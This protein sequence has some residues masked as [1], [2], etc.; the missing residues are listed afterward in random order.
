MCYA[1]RTLSSAER[2]QTVYELECAAAVFGVTK[3]KQYLEVAPF[4]LQTDNAALSWLFEHPKQIGKLGRWILLLSRFKFDIKHIKGRCNNVADC[5]SRMYEG[6]EEVNCSALRE[7]PVTN[8]SLIRHQVNDK[9]CN[10][11]II[12]INGGT[13]V[14][15]YKIKNELLCRQIGKLFS[16]FAAQMANS[17]TCSLKNNNFELLSIIMIKI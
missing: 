12:Q 5:L 13:R 8:D 17:I 15:K 6:T 11:L 16:L 9:F 1:S 7:Y 10:D 2:R 3:F 4:E 14:P